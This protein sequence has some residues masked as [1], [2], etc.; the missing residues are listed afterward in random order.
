M[1][2]REIKDSLKTCCFTDVTHCNFVVHTENFDHWR[3][4]TLVDFDALA[5]ISVA[6]PFNI[7]ATKLFRFAV[8]KLWIE[9]KIRMNEPHLARQFKQ[10]ITCYFQFYQTF[11][12]A[13]INNDHVAHGPQ[14]SSD[15]WIRFETGKTTTLV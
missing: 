13:R 14:F 4:F 10:N 15:D 11:M 9:D 2:R 7:S 8:L 3:S 12:T 5:T 1:E 6:A